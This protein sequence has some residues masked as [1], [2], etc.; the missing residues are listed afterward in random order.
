MHLVAIETTADTQDTPTDAS[1]T[2]GTGIVAGVGAFVFGL[3]SLYCG[4]RTW[5]KGHKALF[6]VGL[7]VPVLWFI[8]ALMKPK[9]PAYGA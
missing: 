4:F 2:S 9:S 3:L 8:G 1:A 7:F 6:V 5:K